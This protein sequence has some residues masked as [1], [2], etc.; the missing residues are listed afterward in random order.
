MILNTKSSKIPGLL[1]TSVVCVA[2]IA[3]QSALAAKKQHDNYAEVAAMVKALEQSEDTDS[4][5]VEMK[6]IHEKLALAASAIEDRKHKDAEKLLEQ[7]RSDIQVVKLRAQ[8]NQLN[9]ELLDALD[10][11]S[12]A[13]SQLHLLQERLQ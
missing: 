6:F 1:L 11:V 10:R 12:A 7:I 8:V 4:A 9:D 2:L 3:S 5:P 13:Q